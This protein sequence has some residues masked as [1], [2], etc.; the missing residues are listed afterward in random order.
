M[1]S[2]GVKLPEVYGVN[3]G[4][5][6]NIQLEKQKSLKGNEVFQEKPCAGQGRAGIGRRRLPL[7]NQA[8]TQT[9]ELSKKIPSVSKIEIRITNQVHS[10][11]PAQ[12]ITNS[13]EATH[14]SPIIID[15]PFYPDPAYRPPTKPLRTPTPGSSQSSHSTNID[16]EINIDFEENSPFEEGVISE[17]YQRPDKIFYQEP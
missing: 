12:S 2:S 13:N 5:D 3:K 15:I 10:T 7:I 14:R 4:L 17:I 16:P 6:P 9:S 1:K 11:A 8:I